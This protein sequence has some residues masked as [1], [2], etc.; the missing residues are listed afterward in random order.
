MLAMVWIS[1]ETG[2]ETSG[3]QIRRPS[4]PPETSKWI[5]RVDQRERQTA[6]RRFGVH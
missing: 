2:V 3:S 6:N 5:L 1:Y 4:Q